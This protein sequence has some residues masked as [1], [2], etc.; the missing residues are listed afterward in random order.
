MK[1]RILFGALTFLAASLSAAD[2]DS[3]EE[4]K[5]AAKKLAESGSYSWKTT[6][7]VGGGTGGGGAGRFRPGPTEGKI[8]KDSVA[9]L[10]MARGDNTTQAVIKGDKG[11]IKTDDGWK[12][13]AELSE[14]D[15]GQPNRGMFL[16]RM[17]RS[18]KMPVAEAEDLLSKTKEIKKTEG[19][20]TAN[21]T[22]EGAKSLLTFGRRPG[23]DAP[24]PKDAKGSVKFWLK[25]GALSKYEFNIQG[26]ITGREDRE[27]EINRTTTVE[28]KDI[29]STNVDV[30]EEAM[31]K[32]S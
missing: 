28:I 21:L 9:V 30:P 24:A 1:Q 32:L 20:Y 6:V 3:Q 26:K 19:V 16:A 11:A 10:S 15:G 14:G 27:I 23:A 12:S 17:L 22:E 5:R 13:L 18:F 29:G 7:D 2:S 8:G 25:D 31:K 4:V